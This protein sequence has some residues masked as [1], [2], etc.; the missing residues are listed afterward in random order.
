MIRMYTDG[1]CSSNPG[2]GGWAYV[3]LIDDK[4]NEGSGH[5]N[6]T[7]NNEMELM[8]VSQGL[9]N[10]KDEELDVNK[11]EIYSDSAYIV[12][13]INQ[14]W[15]K[16]WRLNGW[17]T[18]KKKAIKNRELWVDIIASLESLKRSGIRVKFIKVKGHSGVPLNEYVDHLATSQIRR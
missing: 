5:K 8:A 14:G 9:K 10:V 11:V 13:A 17:K 18:V 16:K 15:I 3:Y 2:P 4:T 1:A 7:T 12:N 6:N